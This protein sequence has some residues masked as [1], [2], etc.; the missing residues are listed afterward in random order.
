[1]LTPQSRGGLGY[2][3]VDCGLVTSTVGCAIFMASHILRPHLSF[4][5]NVSPLRA[6]RI[7]CGATAVVCMLLPMLLAK[8][9][10]DDAEAEATSL[11][12]G[13][14]HPRGAV[15]HTD[16]AAGMASSPEAGAAEADGVA[17]E[18]GVP[19]GWYPSFY[20]R[21]A[22]SPLA[23]L[24]P[25]ILMSALII[26]QLLARKASSVLLFTVST[27][28]FS[29]PAAVL[30]LARAYSEVVGPAMA[31]LIFANAYRKAM[32]YPFDSSVFLLL[33]AGVSM[34]V[35]VASL[36]LSIHFHGD[37]GIITDEAATSSEVNRLERSGR[38]AP[39]AAAALSMGW[40]FH[41]LRQYFALPLDDLRVLFRPSKAGYDARLQN[42]KLE[43]KDM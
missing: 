1:M 16:F 38:K 22:S 39:T 37:F 7:A 31:S 27:S 20:P 6:L 10:A 26:A 17:E 5:L 42:L 36:L 4:V 32:P 25:A 14:A 28:S 12:S 2:T 43:I 15:R 13:Q 8:R 19:S 21:P 30:S 24:L 41:A 18:G 11:F 9:A 40:D 35:Y 3:C 33:T 34:V 29:S 23:V